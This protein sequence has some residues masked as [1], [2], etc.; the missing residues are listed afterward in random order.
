MLNPPRELYAHIF[1]PLP[2]PQGTEKHDGYAYGVL[3]PQRTE[4]HDGYGRSGVFREDGDLLHLAKM[5][6]N[7]PLAPNYHSM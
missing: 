4:K 7:L 5:S 3:I 2:S 1:C 6:H